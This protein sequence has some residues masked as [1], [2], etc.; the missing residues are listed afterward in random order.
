MYLTDLPEALKALPGLT[1]KY[2]SGWQERG[3]GEM[4]AVRGIICHHTAGPATGELPS[5]GT[6]MY[7][8][9]DLAGPLAQLMLGRSGTVYVV[10]AGLCWHAGAGSYA[11]LHGNSDCIGIE[12]ES[13][14]TG[15]WTA[16]QLAAYP[17]LCATL[18]DYY[19]L[20]S[21]CVIAHREWAPTRKVDPTGIAMPEFRDRIAD[22]LVPPI[23]G[24]IMPNDAATI[25]AK[26]DTMGAMPRRLTVVGD[27]R[28]GAQ[29]ATVGRLL[30]HVPNPAAL[31]ALTE[32]RWVDGSAGPVTVTR[33]DWDS[34]V[35]IWRKG[36][37]EIYC[38]NRDGCLTSSPIP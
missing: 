15:D 32:L 33:A 31:S 34:L 36:G 23:E 29:Y 35:A 26:L 21:A 20:S 27:P 30:F 6:V 5:L 11:G 13:A 12:A 10:A 37:G 38:A 24:E 18:V 1:V 4:S 2:I 22:I 9:P 25:L 19:G 8:R 17:L 28:P 3:H 14:G 7:G 16:E